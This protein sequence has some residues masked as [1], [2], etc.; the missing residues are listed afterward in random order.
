[1][2]NKLPT[3]PTNVHA[4]SDLR[5]AFVV[6]GKAVSQLWQYAQE[7]TSA[8]SATV[9]CAD[10]ITRT[11][12]TI[13]SLLTFEN[14][15]RISIEKLC[16]EGRSREKGRDITITI[17]R[18]YSPTASLVISGEELDVSIMKTKV[19]DTI[20]GLK[21][22]YEWLATIDLIFAWLV[23]FLFLLVPS[24]LMNSRG[25]AQV[26]P[27]GN[28]LFAAVIS[29]GIVLAIGL[30]IW[31]VWLLRGRFF[32]VVTFA[33][34]QGIRRYHFDEQIRW[35]VVVGFLNIAT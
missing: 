24:M 17:G 26:F 32:P 15:K 12:D 11:F 21:A 23:V 10:D 35:V 22:W 5:G 20:F 19:S 18:P 1:M 4:D 13:E 14:A 6:D 30:A 33:I 27:A 8:A 16:I 3:S 28:T 29:L 25:T 34:G 7:F 2:A 9:K 31:V